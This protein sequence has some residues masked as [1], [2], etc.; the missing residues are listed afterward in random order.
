[1]MVVA[2]VRSLHHWIGVAKFMLGAIAAMVVVAIATW[3]NADAEVRS[4]MRDAY[5]AIERLFAPQ[6]QVPVAPISEQELRA[7]LKRSMWPPHLHEKVLH[8][9]RCE[10]ARRPDIVRDNGPRG[11]D[12]GLMQVN[13][14]AHIKLIALIGSEKRLLD[15]L[16]NVNIGYLVFTQT[17]QS[18]KPWRA[19]QACHGLIV[20][21][22]QP[23]KKKAPRAT[24]AAR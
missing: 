20:K 22:E 19:S 3:T 17:G 14:Q 5:W 24:L 8:V 23:T 7:L 1:M 21:T 4:K 10:S 13:N 18:W 9:V 15:P 2:I 6:K 16:T 11:F 12:V